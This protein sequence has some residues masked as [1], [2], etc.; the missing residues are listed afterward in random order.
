MKHK[1]AR[2]RGT[3][4]LT[5]LVCCAFSAHFAM[6]LTAAPLLDNRLLMI[7]PSS[8]PITAG[9]ATLTIGV[10]QR[11]NGVYSGEYKMNISPYFFKSETG[12]LAI[13]VSDESLAKVGQGETVAII[14]T[15]ISPGGQTRPIAAK[16]T[17]TG[18]EGG[19]LKLWFT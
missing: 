12:R 10:L 7:D 3:G 14:G 13:V 15:A 9:K 1:M 5:L 17:P 2:W 4:L 6:D 16:A 19:K 18:T 11:T 8:M